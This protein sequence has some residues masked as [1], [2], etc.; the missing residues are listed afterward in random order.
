MHNK[1]VTKF[2]KS[3][4]FLNDFYNKRADFNKKTSILLVFIVIFENLLFLIFLG[5]II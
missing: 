3:F 2:D 5:C 4:L 1:A